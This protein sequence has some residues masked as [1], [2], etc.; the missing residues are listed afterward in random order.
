MQVITLAKTKEY[1]GLGDTTYD[2][3]ITALLPVIDAK[4]KEICKNNFNL[5]VSATVTNT[6]TAVA[7]IDNYYGMSRPD[8][9]QLSKDLPT[10]TLLEGTGIPADAYISEIYYNGITSGD[11][12]PPAFTL[13]EAADD[14]SSIIYAGINIAYQSVIAKGLWWLIGQ[15]ST[16]ICAHDWIS[17]SEGGMSVSRSEADN[18][19]DGKSGMPA[20]FVKSLPRWHR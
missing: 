14:D 4:V 6:E 11:Y 15:T 5:Q 10:G 17:K 3:Q 9:I 19:I 2:A 18:K 12:E 8:I 13:S 1:L 7:L 16:T 20:G